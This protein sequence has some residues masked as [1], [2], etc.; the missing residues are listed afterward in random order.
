MTD[1]VDA[2]QL[3]GAPRAGLKCS[4]LPICQME[5]LGSASVCP[6]SIFWSVYISKKRGKG[7]VNHQRLTTVRTSRKTIYLTTSQDIS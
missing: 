4:P 3:C 5:R 6:S 2:V 7:Q 1:S